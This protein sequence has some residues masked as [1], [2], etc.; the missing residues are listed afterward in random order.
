MPWTVKL[1]VECRWVEA[2]WELASSEIEESRTTSYP[3]QFTR[4]WPLQRILS[5]LTSPLKYR[6]LQLFCF[7][8]SSEKIVFRVYQV[9]IVMVT[10][11][12]WQSSVR[13]CCSCTQSLKSSFL[14]GLLEVQAIGHRN[15]IQSRGVFRSVKCSFRSLLPF[16]CSFIVSTSMLPPKSTRTSQRKRLR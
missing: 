15:V 6:A 13:L 9:S 11:L 10:N 16:R 8:S 12:F 5:H 14:F 4:C 3:S 2:L 7:F 1:V